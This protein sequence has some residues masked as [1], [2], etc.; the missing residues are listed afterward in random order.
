VISKVREPVAVFRVCLALGGESIWT[1]KASYTK[2]LA[3]GMVQGMKMKLRTQAGIKML[4]N[5]IGKELTLGL[6]YSI[7]V[8]ERY[9]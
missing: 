3:R 4:S 7:G 2:D 1:S 8:I 5:Q 6:D 9:V